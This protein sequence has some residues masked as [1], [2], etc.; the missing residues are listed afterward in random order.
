MIDMELYDAVTLPCARLDAGI[1][2]LDDLSCDHNTPGHLQG[3]LDFMARALAREVSAI[4]E[5]L[6]ANLDRPESTQAAAD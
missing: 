4:R 1:A 5:I 3:R 2:M 6:K